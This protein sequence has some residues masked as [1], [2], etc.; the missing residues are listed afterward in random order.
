VLYRVIVHGLS[1][2]SHQ[3]FG[4]MVKPAPCLST[5]ALC[6]VS[7]HTFGGDQRDPGHLDPVALLHE[8]RLGA[9]HCGAT[10]DAPRPAPANEAARWEKGT[11][12]SV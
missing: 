1:A 3:I 10:E 4:S 12:A 6:V 2:L 9:H 5:S 11:K 8:Q 7:G